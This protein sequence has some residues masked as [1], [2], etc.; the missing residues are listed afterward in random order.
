MR[1][2]LK[3]GM[4]LTSGM[5][6]QVEQEISQKLA[7]LDASFAQASSVVKVHGMCFFHNLSK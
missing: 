1:S 5:S 3:F 7:G 6:C 2:S 4:S